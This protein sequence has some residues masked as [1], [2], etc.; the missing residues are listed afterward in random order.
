MSVITTNTS[1]GG[2]SFYARKTKADVI[3]MINR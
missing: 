3:K 2:N 1:D